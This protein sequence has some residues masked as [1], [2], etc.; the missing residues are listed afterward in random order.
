MMPKAPTTRSLNTSEFAGEFEAHT[1]RLLKQRFVVFCTIGAIFGMTVTAI[2]LIV[3]SVSLYNASQE[4]AASAI[5]FI[6]KEAFPALMA[7]GASLIPVVVFIT[8]LLWTQR[9][10]VQELS[11]L[12]LSQVVVILVGAYHMIAAAIGLGGS[13]GWL[14]ASITLLIACVL[15]PWAARSAVLAAGALALLY[16][17][18]RILGG[19]SFGGVLGYAFFIVAL[20]AP[21]VLIAWLKHSQY[22]SQFKMAVLQQRYGEVRRELTDA[23]RI[24]EALFPAR[25]D[26]GPLQLGYQYEPMR[27]IGGDYLYAHIGPG[28][29]GGQRLSV[30]LMDVTGHGI[31][32]ALTVNRLHGELERVFAEDPTIQPGRVLS[33]LN[34]YVHLTLASHSVYVTALCL[35]IDSSTG[36]LEFASGGH[37]PAF[38]IAVD[39]TV[40]ELNSTAL[41][42]GACESEEFDAAQIATDFGPGDTLVAYTDGAI[43]A[44]D[45][46]GKMLGVQGFLR[47]VASLANDRNREHSWSRELLS[48]VEH[49]RYG[50]PADDTLVVEISR[51]LRDAELENAGVRIGSLVEGRGVASVSP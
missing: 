2:G 34:R 43:E 27:Q 20:F 26:A 17:I 51:V 1:L 6:W 14:E 7:V 10:R 25:I 31:P 19:A 33:L 9:G 22:A 21:S 40:R 50:P 32:A 47:L 42:L 29:A 24:H 12:R 15:L 45:R 18:I 44:R 48:A 5:Q 35:R 23:R 3:R 11:L 4:N 30:V 38:L 8:A 16:I 28:V 39:G 37:P 46:T 36:T 13:I 49:F 41:V